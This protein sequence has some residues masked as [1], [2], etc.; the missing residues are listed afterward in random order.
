MIIQ[1]DKEGKS[2]IEQLVDIA[3]KQGGLRNLNAANLTL[4]SMKP[5]PESKKK[6]DKR[7]KKKDKK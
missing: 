7:G 1:V 6:K 2:A 4:H 5:L 3:L